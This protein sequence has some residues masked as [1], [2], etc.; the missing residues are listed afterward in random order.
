MQY[1][2]GELNLSWFALSMSLGIISISAFDL[3]LHYLSIAFLLA[4]IVSTSFLCL[5]F[6]V[7][8]I[9]NYRYISCRRP[10]CRFGV[11]NALA[12][13][14]ILTVRLSLSVPRIPL[15]AVYFLLLFLVMSIVLARPRFPVS[16]RNDNGKVDTMFTI[17]PVAML[18][19]VI[20]VMALSENPLFLIISFAIGIFSISSFFIFQSRFI[21]SLLSSGLKGVV[22]SGAIFINF[23]FPALSAIF[24]NDFSLTSLAVRIPGMAPDLV[25]IARIFWIWATLLI[26][27]VAGIYLAR[28]S[29]F[30]FS[31][32]KL[33][34]VFPAAVYS[35]STFVL[36]RTFGEVFVMISAASL[37]LSISMLTAL[38][39]EIILNGP[40]KQG[41][42]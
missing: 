28:R 31:T 23:G 6:T 9:A 35:V 32:V 27:P 16:I 30:Y 2:S 33:S 20:A 39:V 41:H 37:L 11:F 34:M 5:Y 13:A 22:I 14:A 42:S 19:V 3:H 18:A 8:T 40:Q 7:E 38:I 29:G 24:L 1:G 12:G 26:I 17:F 15:A 21:A 25:L 10:E 36:F 4:D